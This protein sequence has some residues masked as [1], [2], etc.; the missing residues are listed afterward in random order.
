MVEKLGADKTKR[1]P[2]SFWRWFRNVNALGAVALA[3]AGVVLPQYNNLL[4]TGAAVNA[5]QA[6]GGEAMLRRRQRKQSKR[7]KK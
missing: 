6:G 3:G 5:A 1:T 2:E 4:F 7:T